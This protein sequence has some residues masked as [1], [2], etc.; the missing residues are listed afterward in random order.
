VDV[1]E[2]RA[3]CL[4]LRHS[5]AALRALAVALCSPPAEPDMSDEREM[6]DRQLVERASSRDARALDLLVTRLRCVPRMLANFNHRC[7]DAI[8]SGDL[9]DVVQDVLVALWRRL[10]TFT[11]DAAFETW[12]Y[13]YCY[14]EF[15]NAVRKRARRGEMRPVEESSK[16]L[17]GEPSGLEYEGLYRGLASLDR[18]ERRV[19]RL[20]HFDELT[21]EEIGKRLAMSP[22]T[23][24]AMYYRGMQR[25]GER[26]RRSE[27]VPS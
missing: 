10:H 27:E 6:T 24:K 7:G 2:A 26:L 4:F 15:M 20:K 22:N 14:H 9:A 25:L 21:F 19:I 18:S 17:E 5:A 13:G 12:V 23:A 3:G 16:F 11:G 1:A 8:P